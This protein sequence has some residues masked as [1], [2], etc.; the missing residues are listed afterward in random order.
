MEPP[1]PWAL[2]NMAVHSSSNKSN[3]AGFGVV[4]NLLEVGA[5]L[6]RRTAV[7]QH[8]RHQMRDTTRSRC[9]LTPAFVLPTLRD[10]VAREETWAADFRSTRPHQLQSRRSARGNGPRGGRGCL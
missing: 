9:G 10:A 1:T 4:S 7:P 6:P 3:Q 2:G 5:P 8:R